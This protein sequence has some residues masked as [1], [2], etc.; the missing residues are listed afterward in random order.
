MRGTVLIS[1]AG[2]AGLT[3]AYWL[4]KA[5]LRPT[6]VERAPSLRADGYVIDFW[7][8]GYEIAERMGLGSD[9][10]RDG[11]HMREMRIVDDEGQRIT[12]FGIS[13]LRQ[14]T[15]GRFVT[16][17][18]SD[19]VRAVFER[20]NLVAEVNFG[21]EISGLEQDRDGV[22]V[23]FKHSPPR[24]FDLVIGAGGLHS[25]V[26]R[27]VFGPQDRFE[28]SL[29][30]TVA[31][32]ETSGY[33]PRDESVYIIHGEPGR[34]LARFALRDDRTL[35]LF[36]H[37]DANQPPLAHDV[38]TQKALLRRKYA[39]GGWESSRILDELDCA[40]DLY[41]DRVSQI[42]MPRWSQARIAL[43]GDAAFC[44]SLMAGQGSALAM[45]AAY[46][47]AGELARPGQ[48]HSEAFYSYERLLRP[49]IETKQRG[50]KRFSN[51]FAPRTDLGL[52]V[53]NLF[54]RAMSLPGLARY[55]VGKEIRASAPRISVAEM[56]IPK[57]SRAPAARAACTAGVFLR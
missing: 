33:R 22:N 21:D 46:V 55:V 42:H 23:T 32:F 28:R 43:V 48:R 38:P 7:G 6:V 5:G 52:F 1:G 36:V 20:T 8:L 19:L 13:V 2:I 37:A 53:R 30:Y 45:T 4:D 10:E 39:G 29:G 3:S 16:I 31:A 40:Q 9:L 47:L 56:T 51:A 35:F 26:R 24:R 49:F 17:R 41:F 25:G 27:L 15:G 18:R 14:L 12:G 34:M 44:V 50:A 54:I 11:Y 57:K